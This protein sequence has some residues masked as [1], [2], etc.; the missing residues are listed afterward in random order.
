MLKVPQARE[1]HLLSFFRHQNNSLQKLGLSPKE[2]KK[3]R[4]KYIN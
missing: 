3:I 1:A 2:L 4:K